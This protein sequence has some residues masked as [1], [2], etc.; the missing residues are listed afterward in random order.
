H[1]AL[2]AFQ[3][4]SLFSPVQDFADMDGARLGAQLARDALFDDG[5]AERPEMPQANLTPAA[6]GP[7]ARLDQ[8]LAAPLSRRDL[9]R[10][11]FAGADDD[12]RR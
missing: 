8:Q 9:L 7:L 11:R 4:C 1:D 2:G 6:P 10:G 12:P 3:M 5:N